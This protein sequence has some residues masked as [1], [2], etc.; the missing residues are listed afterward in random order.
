MTVSASIN[1]GGFKPNPINISVGS[2]VTWTNNDA[3]V[4]GVVPSP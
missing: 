2:S 1:G 3:S 4:H